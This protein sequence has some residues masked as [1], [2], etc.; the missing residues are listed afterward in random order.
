MLSFVNVHVDIVKAYIKVSA[1]I[2]EHCMLPSCCI[3]Q[4]CMGA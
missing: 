3:D 1:L 4:Y 2:K